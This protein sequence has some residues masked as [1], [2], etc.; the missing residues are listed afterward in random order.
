M[1]H[2]ESRRVAAAVAAA[3]AIAAVP[4]AAQAQGGS[5]NNQ[6]TQP[7][8]QSQNQALQPITPQAFVTAASQSNAFEIASSRLVRTS[9]RR[10]DVR[11]IARDLIRDHTAQQQALGTVAGQLGLQVPTGV[12]TAQQALL[13]RIRTATSRSTSRDRRY[14]QAQMTAH[15]QAIVLH[16]QAVLTTTTPAPLR[17][18]AT[19]ALPILGMHL[20]EVELARSASGSGGSSSGS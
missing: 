9:S 20:G 7:Q 8:S 4:A 13:Q 18:S 10:A 11:R 19:L 5:Q 16:E 3:V 6:G 12:S 17:Q 14:L 15:Q 1:P 2:L